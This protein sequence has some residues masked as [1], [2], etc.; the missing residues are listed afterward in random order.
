M[1]ATEVLNQEWTLGELP[2]L[3]CESDGFPEILAAL[4]AGHSATIGGT[5][6]SSCALVAATLAD[7]VPDTLFVV[8]AHVSDVDALC[9]DIAS[10][11]GSRSDQGPDG[12]GAVPSFPAWDRLP[13]DQ[14]ITDQTYGQRLRLL[15]SLSAKPPRVVVTS[16]QALLQPV[17]SP[18][19]IAR[20]SRRLDVGELAPLDEL[21]R[22]LIEHGFVRRDAVEVPGEIS[23]R[24]GILDILPPDQP[25][26]LRI[27]FF[28]D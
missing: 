2:R 15:K 11:L 1:A 18:D 17:P 3:I 16:I 6:G 26:P 5:W 8:A 24:G 7:E 19:S 20:D 25:A 12:P 27:E 23:L 10:F 4:A 14:V 21:L 28:G 13:R 9:E 22:W